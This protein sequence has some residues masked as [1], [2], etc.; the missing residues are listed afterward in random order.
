MCFVTDKDEDDANK[1]CICRLVENTGKCI[2]K[3]F[4]R[5]AL[6]PRGFPSGFCKYYRTIFF[7]N[8]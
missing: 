3:S 8:V 7:R 5:W 1:S 6:H 4:D 2:A